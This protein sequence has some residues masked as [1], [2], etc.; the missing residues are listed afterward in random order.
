MSEITGLALRSPVKKACAQRT[1]SRSHHQEMNDDK[2]AAE[3][4]AGRSA[5]AFGLLPQRFDLDSVHDRSADRADRRPICPKATNLCCDWIHI[6]DQR[7][8]MAHE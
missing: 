5:E 2:D 4:Y 3:R 8:V 6:E 1:D 7:M